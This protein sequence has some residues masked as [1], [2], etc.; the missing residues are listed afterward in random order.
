M[1]DYLPYNHQYKT[2]KKILNNEEILLTAG[3]SSGKTLSHAIPLFYKIKEN[4]IDKILLLYPTR[5]LL[6][7]Q[8]REMSKLAEIYE[9]E[10]EITEIKGGMSRSEVIKS[11]NKK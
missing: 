8:L 4:I 2:F 11:L 10:N 6:Q 5:A 3:T 1:G 9:L 7:D